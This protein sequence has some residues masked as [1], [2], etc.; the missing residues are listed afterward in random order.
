[1]F[2]ALDVLIYCAGEAF[3]ALRAMTVNCALRD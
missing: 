2:K 3:L 1:V